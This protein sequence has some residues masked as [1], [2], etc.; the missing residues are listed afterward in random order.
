[1][2]KLILASSIAVVM[3]GSLMTSTAFAGQEGIRTADEKQSEETKNELIGFGSGVLAGAA[4]GGPVGAAIGG[5]FG[6]FVADSVNTNAEMEEKDII[7]AGIENELSDTE[8]RIANLSND[9][10]K[11]KEEQMTQLVN[12]EEQTNDS[13]LKDF[14]HFETNLQFKT[15]SAAIEQD[16]YTQLES[17]ATLLNRYPQLNIKLT[18]YADQRGDSEYNYE[19]SKQRATSVEGFLLE[20]G[21]EKGQITLIAEGESESTVNADDSVTKLNL[22]ELYFERRVNVQMYN[23]NKQLASIN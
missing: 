18:G 1:M 15:A 12:F 16:Y 8:V 14:E 17:I 23:A 3:T 11:L 13:W 4:V 10:Q 5:L 7:I 22:E 2:K 9:Y 21:V 6:I 19:L 20:K